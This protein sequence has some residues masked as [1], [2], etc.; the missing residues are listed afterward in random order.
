VIYQPSLATLQHRLEHPESIAV[1]STDVERAAKYFLC[2]AAFYRDEN[3]RQKA[4][5]E[6]LDGALGATGDWQLSL[7]WADNIKPDGYLV[8]R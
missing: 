3:E 5:K 6:I 2:A 8:D 7:G 1:T 4:I